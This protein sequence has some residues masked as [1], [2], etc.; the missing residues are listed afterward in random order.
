MKESDVLTIL[1]VVICV[2][3]LGAEI[4]EKGVFGFAPS[5]I[6]MVLLGLIVLVLSV[7]MKISGYEKSRDTHE[8]RSPQ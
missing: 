7:V 3:S 4:W 6:E 8:K 5:N 2:F 1:G